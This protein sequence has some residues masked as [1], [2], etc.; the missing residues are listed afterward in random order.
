MFGRY[1][2]RAGGVLI[3]SPK[4]FIRWELAYGCYHC[5]N[6]RE[7]LHD[8]NYAPICERTPDMPPRMADPHEWIK[9]I[10]RREWFYNDATPEPQKMKIAK[11]KLVEWGMLEPVMAEIEEAIKEWRTSPERRFLGRFV[12]FKSL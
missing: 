9:H 1:Q 6:G 3:A 2:R 8:R 12:A 10:V 7:V 4:E 5:A 11:A